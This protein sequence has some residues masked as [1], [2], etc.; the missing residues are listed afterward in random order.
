MKKNE[1]LL[2][3]KPD[4]VKRKLIGKIISIL[5]E[6]FS[7]TNIV[8]FKFD[9]IKAEKFY[10]EHRKKDF[11]DE[12]I[13]FISSDFV[14]VLILSGDENIIY[15]LRLCVGNTDFNKADKNTIRGL[16]ATGLTT[17]VVHASDSFNS[18]LREYAII[19]NS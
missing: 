17:N 1:S 8:F 3:I 5:E 10:F 16:F 11:Y 19:F 12:L 13:S 6:K 9:K 2:I 4:A 14:V 18:Y 15:D 7:I